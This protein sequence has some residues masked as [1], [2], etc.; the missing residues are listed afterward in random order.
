MTRT[1]FVFAFA[2]FSR[3]GIRREGR[4]RREEWISAGVCVIVRVHFSGLSHRG[5]NRSKLFIV[6]LQYEAVELIH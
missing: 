6:I 1:V 4:K 5:K 3:T 2:L